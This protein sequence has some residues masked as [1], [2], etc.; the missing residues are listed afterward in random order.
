MTKPA[1]STIVL[2]LALGLAVGGAGYLYFELTDEQAKLVW[3]EGQLEKMT[4]AKD[5][6]EKERDELIQTK[7]AL[8]NQLNE[9]TTQAQTLSEQ[10]AQEKRARQTL[11]T[12]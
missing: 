5:S 6:L 2:V 1:V 7:L 9:S 4:Q 12:E 8:E 11:T 10:L 3:T